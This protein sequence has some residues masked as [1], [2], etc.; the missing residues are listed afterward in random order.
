MKKNKLF[1]T[2]MAGTIVISG[3]SA[4]SEKKE[5]NKSAQVDTSKGTT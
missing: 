1:L 2:L 3:C 5:E 4:K